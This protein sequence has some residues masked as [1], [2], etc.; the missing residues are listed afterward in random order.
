MCLSAHAHASACQQRAGR[1]LCCSAGGRCSVA[2]SQKLVPHLSCQEESAALA[3]GQVHCLWEQTDEQADR[4][5]PAAGLN[6]E[7]QDQAVCQIIR[8]I[9]VQKSHPCTTPRPLACPL[10]SASTKCDNQSAHCCAPGEPV[11]WKSQPRVHKLKVALTLSKETSN[12]LCAAQTQSCCSG[13]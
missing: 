7:G 3:S 10:A 2:S 4:P 12:L 1:G 5:S 11:T 6:G 9:P 8:S 13:R